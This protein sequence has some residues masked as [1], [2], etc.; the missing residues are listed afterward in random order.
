[1]RGDLGIEPLPAI[2]KDTDLRGHRPSLLR[3][4][5]YSS[6]SWGSNVVV[7]L[8][9]VPV[10]VAY[11]GVEGYG[12]YALLSGLVGY[13]GLLDF[14][15]GQGVIKFVAE[16]QGRGEDQ[17]VAESINSALVVQVLFGG[18]G[19]LV[20]AFFNRSI[21]GFLK[22][23]SG[24]IGEAS[25]C[26]YLMSVGFFVSMASSTFSSALMG[27]QMFD[28]VSK[29]SVL[30]SVMTTVVTILALLLGGGLVHVILLTV[31]STTITGVV[32]FAL[33]RTAL[34][35]YRMT[36][37]VSWAR[38]K[39]IV[40]YSSYLFVLR[41]SSVLNNY[42]VRLVV[43]TYGGPQ[44]V[45]FFVAPQKLVLA[46]QGAMGSS[47]GVL[48]PFTS[49]MQAKGKLDHVR[50]IFL[51]GMRYMLALSIPVFFFLI[52]FPKEVMHI[53]MGNEFASATWLVLI[54]L[55][56][57]QWLAVLTM[58]PA[59]TVM[60]M[61]HSRIVA[62]FS[63]TAAALNLVFVIVLTSAYGIVGAAAGVMI[64]AVQGPLFIWYVT[65]HIL[66]INWSDFISEVIKRLLKPVGLFVG[67]GALVVLLLQNVPVLP[68]AVHLLIGF[69][70][71]V[72]YLIL[73]VRQHII[74]ASDF[75][76]RRFFERSVSG[77]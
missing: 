30:S 25:L 6:L 39:A 15:L 5:F 47:T 26:L 19:L 62:V 10:F 16:Y 32:F 23:S 34:G 27:L 3:N 13:F 38:V 68:T 45:A 7:N 67:C 35:T 66:E 72:V 44:S 75:Q 48:F 76:F 1:V 60:G 40:G 58:I 71:V 17:A 69:G 61:G 56:L 9:A 36:V 65:T 12:I 53:W 49:E 46:A 8:I 29:V 59:S 70:L 4:S 14:G 42:F 77:I 20:L 50:Q 11:L 24:S 54:F 31:I 2:Y 37:S 41:L 52:F 73:I 22:V 64:T 63:A 21:L 51:K 28:T 57:A 33:L 55:S 74:N 43:S 18:L